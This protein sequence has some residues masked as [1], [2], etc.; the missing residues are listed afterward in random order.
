VAS[1]LA[2]N[3]TNTALFQTGGRT[4]L[5]YDGFGRLRVRGECTNN[6]SPVLV[7]VIRERDG[8]N[9]PRV[10]YTLGHGL[11]VR[12]DT[13]GSAFFHTDGNG[14]VTTLV[15]GQGRIKARY[16]YDPFG[17]LLAKYGD[18]ADAN[19]R[20]FSGKEFHARSGLYYYGFRWYDPN[21]QRWVNADPIGLA[22]GRNRHAFV[23]NNPINWR[24]DHGLFWLAPSERGDGRWWRPTG[25]VSYVVSSFQ[26]GTLGNA[27]EELVALFPNTL[28]AVG[29]IAFDTV[30][31]GL[32]H[33]G[34]A[35]DFARGAMDGVVSSQWGVA[36]ENTVYAGLLW[37]VIVAEVSTG[38]GSSTVTQSG[39]KC[40]A[41]GGVPVTANFAQT[42]FRES[43]SKAGATEISK[44][45]GMPIKTIDDLAAALQSGA[46]S[47]SQI[48]VNVINRGGNTLILNTRTAQALERAGIPRSQWN[49]VNQTGNPLFEQMLT[50]QLRRNQLSPAGT[51]LTF[52]E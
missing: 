13:N 39:L 34:L 52:P 29:N 26:P 19:T 14:N 21:L 1:F 31:S 44:I 28:V 11:L 45:T 5:R 35:S 2:L 42:S 8:N 20:R 3:H 7:D 48:P 40:A 27:A 4:E 36:V 23:S 38:G 41:K 16:L 22:G 24:D 17:N 30:G 9:N 47:P 43:F 46:V 37:G 51:P 50:D 25:P 15:H 49:G 12:T 6:T 18:L 10:S 33:V 32:R